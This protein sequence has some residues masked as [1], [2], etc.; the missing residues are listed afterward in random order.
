MAQHEKYLETAIRDA[1]AAG[2]IHAP[3]PKAKARMVHA[4]HLG[5]MTEARIANSLEVLRECI[6]GTREL[7]GV[8]ESELVPA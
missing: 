7:L 4:Y 2:L 1:H 6:R 3:D 8:K 5:L